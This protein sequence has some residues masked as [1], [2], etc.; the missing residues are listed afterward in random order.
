MRILKSTICYILLFGIL[1][2]HAADIPFKSADPYLG[3]IVVEAESGEVLFEDNADAVGYPASVIKLLNL[4][5]V[6]EEIDAGNIS[7]EDEIRVT[8]EAAGMG[9]SQVYLAE[10]EVFSVEDLLYAMIVQSANDAATALAIYI[11]GSKEA[12][13]EMMRD[14]AARIGMTS[15]DVQSVH[16]LPPGRGQAPDLT[17]ARD[18]ALLSR[19]LVKRPDVFPYTSTRERDFRDGKFI[20]RTHNPLLLELPGCDGLKT[21]YF[22]RAGFSISATMERHGNRIIAVLLDSKV[23]KTRNEKAAALLKNGFRE[24]AKRRR[25]RYAE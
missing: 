3:A 7:L 4:L 11:A 13:V 10:N 23:R 5:V 6:L 22:S 24:L 15:T 14:T 16:G 8:A 9:G 19:E 18:L 1:A 12:Y 17:T 25:A 21:G 2:A 20:M